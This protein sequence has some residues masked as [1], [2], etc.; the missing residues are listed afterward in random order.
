MQDV[1]LVPQLVDKHVVQ[2]VIQIVNMLADEDVHKIHVM[3]AVK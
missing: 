3:I 2:L 1:L